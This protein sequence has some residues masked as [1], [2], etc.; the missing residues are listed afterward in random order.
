[1]IV[2]T[3]AT[4][5]LGSA[6]VDHLLARVPAEQ[7]GVSVRDP[8]KASALAALGVRVRGAD[9]EHPATLVAAFEGAT[10]VL[11][12]SASTTGEEVLR[13]HRSAIDAARDAGVGRIVYT[14]HMGANPAS[15]FPPMPDHAGTESFLVESGVPF[16]SLRNG[17]YAASG[18]MLLRQGLESGV[19]AAP[20]DGPVSWTA[21]ADL[22][23]AAAIV[24][25]DGGLDGDF[26]GPTPALTGSESLDL[27]DLTAI[28]SELTGRTITRTVVSDDAFRG[29]MVSHGAPSEVADMLV[30]LFVASRQG[31]FATVDPTLGRLLGRPPTSARDVLA[32]SLS[33]G[34]HV[35]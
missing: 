32:E 26:D 10:Q 12:V 28:A 14:S 33:G 23:E 16:T 8:A 31:E 13:L 6:V 30:N 35:S 18:L 4:G 3:G 21:H 11:L 5:Q 24:L 19:V 2:V 1:M 29:G 25:S 17:F 15:A 9:F 20:A 34:P 27:T 22:A 7:V